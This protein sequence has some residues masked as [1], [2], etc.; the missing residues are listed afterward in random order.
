MDR[1]SLCHRLKQ[2]YSEA[3]GCGV[4][5][6]N[7]P[8]YE[9]IWFVVPPPAPKTYKP[10]DA[11]QRARLMKALTRANFAINKIKAFDEVDE[12]DGVLSYLFIRQEALTSSR[13][14]GTWSTIDE[15]LTPISISDDRGKSNHASVRG[16]AEALEKNFRLIKE[17]KAAA[18][19]I[20]L[21]CNLHKT[22]VNKD[23]S[24]NGVPGEIRKPGTPRSIVQIGGLGRKEESVYNPAPPHHVEK[25]LKDMMLWFQDDLLIEMGDAGQGMSLP[26]RMAIS[27]AHF[28]A[29]HPYSDGNG[30]VGR[31]LWPLQMIVSNYAPL[32]L[33]GYVEAQKREYYNALEQAQK[34]LDYLPLIEFI[35]DAFH[36][37]HFNTEQTR[38][39]L[40]DL[41]DLWAKKV[42]FR[43]GSAGR[44]TLNLLIKSPILSI[45]DLSRELDLS[46][47][48]ASNAIA[49]LVAA[50]V[51]TERTGYKKHRIFAAEEVIAIL[52][53]KFGST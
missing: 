38:K 33:S 31:M 27:H 29:I 53:R 11:T 6:I 41:P 48:A 22:I 49:K 34:K 39:D 46:F 26:I 36:A 47:Q 20:K 15:I 43:Q 18:F 23:P 16:Y 8:G 5:K 37:S 1:N 17:K 51:L 21:I 42:R 7:A 24:F 52:A 9:N 2:P 45:S 3:H 35:C 32:Y 50:G 30:R 25:C 4:E 10:T 40:L 13:L 14:E 12:F 19:T 44:K 28:E